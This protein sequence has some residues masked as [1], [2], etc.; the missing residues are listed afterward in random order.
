MILP[1]LLTA[2]TPLPIWETLYRLVESTK[3]QFSFAEYSLFQRALFAKGTYNF[4]DSTTF[5]CI[6]SPH[7]RNSVS[8]DSDSSVS[9]GTNS[10]WDCGLIWICIEKFEMGDTHVETSSLVCTIHVCMS[11]HVYV[12]TSASFHT[13]MSLRVCVSTCVSSCTMSLH[14]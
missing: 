12:S 8:S 1:I 2:A 13:S 3:S 11:L 5:A 10:N 9:R 4:I 7:L 6:D 14:V